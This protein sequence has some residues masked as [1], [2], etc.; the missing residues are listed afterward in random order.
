MTSSTLAAKR[1]R[2]EHVNQAIR[3]IANHGNRFFFNDKHQRYARVEVDDR[4]RVWFVDDYS[5][6]RIYTHP[7]TWGGR[8][9]GFSHGGTLRSLVE[10]FRD[11]IRTGV[12]LTPSWLGLNRWGGGEYDQ[13][14]MDAVR[15]QAGALPVF[16]Q[17][18]NGGAP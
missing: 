13:P 12:P 11:Y 5:N 9:K 3:I 1:Q 8:W 4:G 6:K 2:A 14:V 7:T 17:Q 15:Q 10:L 16:T 18:G